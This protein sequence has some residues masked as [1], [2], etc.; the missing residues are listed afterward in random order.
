MRMM[1]L[2]FC[3]TFMG[4]ITCFVAFVVREPCSGMRDLSHWLVVELFKLGGKRG[5]A[6]MGVGCGFQVQFLGVIHR[7]SP[8]AWTRWLYKN[9]CIRSPELR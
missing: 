2:W 5:H 6:V 3:L 7:F 8:A 1:R 4:L 9:P